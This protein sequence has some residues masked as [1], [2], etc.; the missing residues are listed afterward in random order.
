MAVLLVENTNNG[1]KTC[2]SRCLPETQHAIILVVG[3]KH[4]QRRKCLMAL[5]QK[6]K[7]IERH[8]D[9]FIY[10]IRLPF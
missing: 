5:P 1:V 2:K 8:F 7:R 9:K 3:E 4:Q 6:E 10:S